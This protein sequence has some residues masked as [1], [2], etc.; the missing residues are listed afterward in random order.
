MGVGG[1]MRQY[2]WKPA[3]NMKYI[4]FRL[5]LKKKTTITA[6]I[7]SGKESTKNKS[8]FSCEPHAIFIKHMLT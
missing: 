2:L 8:K 4:L 1:E 3:S 5:S 6:I 7:Q